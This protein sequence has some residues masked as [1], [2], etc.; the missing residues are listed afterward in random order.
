MTD[1]RMANEGDG[2]Q[3]LGAAALSFSLI[4]LPPAFESFL[5]KRGNLERKGV[6]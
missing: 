5:G 2:V 4:L 1:V 6:C 3:A